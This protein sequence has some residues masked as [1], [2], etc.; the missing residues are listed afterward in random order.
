MQVKV[1]YSSAVKRLAAAAVADPETEAGVLLGQVLGMTRSQLFLTAEQELPVAARNFFESLLKRRLQGEPTAYILGECEF[2]SLPFRV[3]REVLIPRPETEF[4]LEK[5][6]TTARRL[7]TEAFGPVLD[8]GVGSGVIAIVLALEMPHWSEI[9]GVDRSS[10]A[11]QIARHNAGKHGVA[12]RVT[13]INSHL[14]SGLAPRQQFDLIVTNPPYVERELLDAV[15]AVLQ[16]EVVQYEPRL[17]LDGGR[18]GVRV[19]HEIAVGLSMVLK[20]GG[21]FF[22]EI[23]AGQAAYVIDLF[24]SLNFF[25]SLQIH[26][27]YAGLPRVFQARRQGRDY[28]R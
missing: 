10:A 13:F 3:S 4:L 1:L 28:Q 24:R 2:W 23:G 22:M 21:W 27:D 11:L 26:K 6:L 12:N 15:P 7:T 17:A 8:M 9:Y 14:F 5:V 20:P 16:R 19:I 25:D 18:Q